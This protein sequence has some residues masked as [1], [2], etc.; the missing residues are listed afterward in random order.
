V[1]SVEIPLY[2]V[3]LVAPIDK[4][5]GMRPDDAIELGDYQPDDPALLPAI[6]G[7]LTFQ[8]TVYTLALPVQSSNDPSS[9][10]G[11]IYVELA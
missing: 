1:S 5:L 4:R 8:G 10:A 9:Y 3:Y 6:G 2:R 11:D 7:T